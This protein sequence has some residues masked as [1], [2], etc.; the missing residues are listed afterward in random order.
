MGLAH[1][2]KGVGHSVR[3]QERF[4][5][6]FTH[7]SVPCVARPPY[8]RAALTNPFLSFAPGEPEQSAQPDWFWRPAGVNQPIQ[9]TLAA[10]Q[11]RSKFSNGE[12]R[13]RRVGRR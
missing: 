3:D 12:E 9:M 2:G 8:G 4:D 13:R 6:Y 10:L 11:H 1:P 5:G 7:G